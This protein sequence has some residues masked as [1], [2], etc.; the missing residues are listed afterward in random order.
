MIAWQAAPQ[1]ALDAAKYSKFTAR[2]EGKIVESWL[3]I[4]WIPA[5]MGELLRWH[6]FARTSPCAI[7]EY[8]GDWGAPARRAFCGNRFNF[9]E[10]DTLHDITQ[11][12]PDV[13]FAWAHDERGFIVPEIRIDRAG[14]QWL[15]SHPPNSTFM[16]SKPPPSTALEALQFQVNRPVEEAIA[17]WSTRTPTFALALDRERPADAMPAGY[18]E[19]RRSFHHRAAGSCFCWLPCPALRSGSRVWRCCSATCRRWRAA[20][21]RSCRCLPCP[22]GATSFRMH[23]AR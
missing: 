22:G 6:A 15:S 12:A 2:A 16:L 8:A 20:S 17:S 14:L 10:E 11:M 19:S 18:V 3:A 5:D 1:R 13:P 4:E 7:V 9:R 23:C 21:C